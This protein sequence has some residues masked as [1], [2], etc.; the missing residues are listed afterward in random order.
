MEFCAW[1][2]G[3]MKRAIRDLKIDVYG[4]LQTSNI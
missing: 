2:N 4:K 1:L 3:K